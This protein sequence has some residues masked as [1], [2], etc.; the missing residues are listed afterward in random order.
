MRKIKRGAGQEMSAGR[1]EYLE[2]ARQRERA[3][4]LRRTVAAVVLLTA[5][6]AYAT[7]A[8]G[9]SLVAAK[10]LV[11]TVRIAVMP[12]QGYPQQTGVVELYQAEPLSGGFVVL[13]EEGC[14]VYSNAGNRLSSIQTG[15][16]R[17]AIAA[18]KNRFVLYNRSGNELRVESRTQN[19]YTKTM[20]HN[21]YL[22]AVA[23]GGQVAVVTD[24]VRHMAQLTVYSAAMEQ[25]LS[26]SLTS[27]EGTPLRMEFSPDSK[28]L[29]VAAAT[30]QDGQMVANLYVLDLRQGDPVQ[31]DAAA[32]SVPQWIGWLS[33]STVLALF[34]DHASLY[35]ASGGQ[36]ARFDYPLGTLTGLSVDKNGAAL[37]FRS[38]Q[39]CQAV[40]LD[41]KLNVQYSG[42]VP[43]ANQIVRAGDR[44]YLLCDSSVECFSVTGEYQWNQVCAAKPQALLAEDRLLLFSGNTVEQLTPDQGE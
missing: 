23:D 27:A 44:F 22:C 13:G 18:G 16:A 33:D 17:P 10:D 14:V 41:K 39:T 12:E 31:L 30:A 9:S 7:G 25:Q 6:V 28:R 2:Q 15:Y 26:W 4:R 24:D 35:S 32:G 36:Q 11:D 43:S 29:A 40:I 19:L 8:V 5:L 42:G 20:E 37:L 1:V 34:D 21:I 38:G 3:R